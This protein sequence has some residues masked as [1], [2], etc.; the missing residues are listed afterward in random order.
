MVAASRLGKKRNVFDPKIPG[1]DLP[2]LLKVAAIYGPNASGK[3]SLVK[4]MNVVSNL[5][6]TTP[7]EKTLIPVEPFRF[8]PALKGLPSNF[9][10][11]F[12]EEG[13]R[14]QFILSATSD[15]IFEETLISYPKGKETLLYSRTF[16]PE[17]GETYNIGD[18]LEGGEIVHNAWRKLTGPR[19]L[20]LSQAVLNSSEELNQLRT[21]YN[22]FKTSSLCIAHDGM[23][24]WSLLS[25]SMLLQNDKYKIMLQNFL[26]R[27]DVPI[28]KIRFEEKPNTKFN[29]GPDADLNDYVKAVEE[30]SKTKLTHTTLLGDAEFDFIEESGG[31]QNLMGFWLPWVKLNYVGSGGVVI[32]DELDSSLHPKIVEKLVQEHIESDVDTQLIFTTHDTHLMN[33]KLLRR[34]Q[35]WVAERDEYGATQLFSIHDFQGRDSEDMEKRYYEGRYRGLPILSRS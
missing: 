24:T 32:V 22:W 14:F 18:T 4:A 3:S 33:T 1:D 31:T 29:I 12:I 7:S 21:P 20:F 13:L 9:E 17:A 35:F 23:S 26:Q 6:S 30:N 10:I 25:R 8:D 5:L 34:D 16:N 19:T 15:R 27:V 2:R 28:T 11:N